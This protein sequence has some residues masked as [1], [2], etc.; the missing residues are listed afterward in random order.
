[1][2]ENELHLQLRHWHKD[3]FGWALHCCVGNEADAEDVLQ[4][5]YLKVLEGKAK[6]DGKSSFKTW[7]FSVIRF[8]A[9]D[10]L[11]RQK[12]RQ[13]KM[14]LI[15]K[16]AFAGIEA[17]TEPEQS[18]EPDMQKFKAALD[19]LPER[20]H[21]VLLLVFYHEN[22][23]AEAALIMGVSLGTARTHYERGK[24]ALRR[25]LSMEY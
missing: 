17:D 2:T 8:T 9:I 3:S 12:V 6:F 1:M 21:E 20:Q 24:D 11:R 15:G 25:I 7:L 16:E 14:E 5:V 4:N 23:I 13:T 18:E 22:S 10:A 19:T